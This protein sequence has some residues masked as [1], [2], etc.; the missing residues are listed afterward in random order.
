MKKSD[1]YENPGQKFE[2]HSLEALEAMAVSIF[3]NDNWDKKALR[4]IL[5][6]RKRRLN[7]DFVFT[8]EDIDVFLWIDYEIKKCVKKLQQQGVEIIKNLEKLTQEK[9]AFFNDFEVE[10]FIRPVIMEW[11]E[12]R[13]AEDPISEIINWVEGDFILSFKPSIEHPNCCYFGDLNWNDHE[14]G[15]PKGTFAGHH[16]GYGMHELCSHSLW[17][18][19]DMMRISDIDCDLKVLYQHYETEEYEICL[20]D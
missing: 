20:E 8:P 6:E 4:E 18:F 11:I 5:E 19:P 10:A 14:L 16:I 12:L 13:I 2:K 7:K 9:G 17:S 3:N 1:N 15:V